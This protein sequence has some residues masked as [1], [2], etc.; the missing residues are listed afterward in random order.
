MVYG[1]RKKIKCIY[2]YRESEFHKLIMCCVQN[3]YLFCHVSTAYHFCSLFC[4]VNQVVEFHY[5]S[6][7]V[8]DRKHSLDLSSP[9]VIL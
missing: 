3:V 4:H 2:S 5:D 8:E 1:H 9:R 6:S 7:I